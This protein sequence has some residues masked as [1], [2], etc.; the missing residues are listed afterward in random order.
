MQHLLDGYRAFRR[1]TWPGHKAVFEELAKHG[2]KPQTMVVACSDSRVSPTMIF[3]AGPGE[4][5]TVRN[6][7]NIVPPYAPG[8][9]TQGT[10]AALEFGVRALQ[11][12]S[13]IV[14]GHA[15]CGGVKAL[16]EG[17]PA[18]VSDFV[19]AWLSI[20]R[21][22]RRKTLECVAVEERQAQGEQE[23]VKLSLR[24]L[25]GFPWIAERV[26]AGTLRLEGAIF[27]IRSGVLQVLG[28][29]GGFR[30]A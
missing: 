6:V 19:P 30:P 18:P 9:P 28:E 22:A 1:T 29:D 10:S 24:N 25:M 14:L 17:A 27:D 5:F 23:V 15:M 12:S 26:A 16:L 7:A 2:Q 8:H 20:A 3:N 4:L 11:V 13:I 21:E